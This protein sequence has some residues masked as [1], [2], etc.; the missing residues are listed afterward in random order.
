MIAKLDF[1]ADPAANELAVPEGFEMVDG[2]LVEMPTMSEESN[3]IGGQ[4]FV[5]INEFVRARSL[6]RVYPQDTPFRGFPGERITVRK[7]DAAFVRKDRLS[8]QLSK[9][10]LTIGPDLAAEVL[11]PTDPAVEVNRKVEQY[12]A[13]GVRLVWVVDPDLRLIYVHRPNGTNSVIREPAELDGE[14]V[15]PGFCCP[16]GAFIPP[17]ES[18][19]PPSDD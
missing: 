19:A 14:D 11:S 12:L 17:V 2:E 3:W 4:L 16:I 13:A 15:L 18:Q 5:V 10:D 7:P 6:G 9:W 1:D 8:P